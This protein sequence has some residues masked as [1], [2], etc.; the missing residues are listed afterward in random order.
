MMGE[1][2]CAAVR[3]GRGWVRLMR[4]SLTIFSNVFLSVGSSP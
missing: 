2:K 3:R 4:E 1:M